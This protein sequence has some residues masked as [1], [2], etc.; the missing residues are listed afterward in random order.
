[1]RVAE[2]WAV[3]KIFVSLATVYN[4]Y[5]ISCWRLDRRVLVADAND[6]E[7]TVATVVFFVF[8]LSMVVYKHGLI[9]NL[10]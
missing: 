3:F 5:K 4:K 6:L 7:W 2:I 8:F 1:M 10:M 9:V